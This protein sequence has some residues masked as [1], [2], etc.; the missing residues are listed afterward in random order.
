MFVPSPLFASSELLQVASIPALEP[1]VYHN[2][3]YTPHHVQGVATATVAGL[4]PRH[5]HDL[6]LGRTRA[7]TLRITDQLGSGCAMTRVAMHR[8]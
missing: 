8:R 3:V 6:D 5:P 4:V 7:F 1:L 2:E